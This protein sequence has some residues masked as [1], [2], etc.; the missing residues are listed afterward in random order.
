MSDEIVDDVRMGKVDL[1]FDFVKEAMEHWESQGVT[2]PSKAKIGDYTMQKY[3]VRG[4]DETIKRYRAQVYAM[5]KTS[6]DAIDNSPVAP[7]PPLR[8]AVVQS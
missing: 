7:L 6:H 4:R 3:K 5:R 8:P 2:S 1:T